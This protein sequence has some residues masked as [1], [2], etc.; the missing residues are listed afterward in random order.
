MGVAGGTGSPIGRLSLNALLGSGG[1]G[2]RVVTGR[3]G[4]SGQVG[5]ASGEL[6]PKG[7]VFVHGELWDAVARAGAIPS[8]T[9]VRIV[10]VEAMELTVEPAKRD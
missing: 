1:L 5:V 9:P 2:G 4:M 7:K 8:G 10:S 3:E 6:N